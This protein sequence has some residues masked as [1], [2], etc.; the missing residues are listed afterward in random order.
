MNFNIT[1]HHVTITDAL[2]AYVEEKLA[3]VEGHFG[4]I[5]GTQIT[6]KVEKYLH[7]AE[8][9]MQLSGNTIH[10]DAE[11]EDMYAAIDDLV[12]KL[13]KQVRRYKRKIT[14]HRA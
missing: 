8:A 13:D 12:D 14:N 10:A 9:T 7:K 3:R 6:L 2:K 4:N 11:K 1:G 5:T